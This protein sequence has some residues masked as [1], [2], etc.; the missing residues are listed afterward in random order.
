MGRIGISLMS[1][2][3][4]ELS[5]T[6]SS[7]QNNDVQNQENF[8]SRDKEWDNILDGPENITNQMYL[9]KMINPRLC[10]NK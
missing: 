7:S 3:I 1:S 10:P 8:I 6:D 2:R 9:H 5:S 4:K